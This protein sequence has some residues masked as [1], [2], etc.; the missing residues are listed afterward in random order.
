M[1]V[2]RQA[3][4]SG[5]AEVPHPAAHRQ[6]DGGSGML[7]KVLAWLL[8]VVAVVV[9]GW[10]L[11]KGF[12]TVTASSSVKGKQYQALFLT[13]GQVYFGK[14]SQLNGQ[15][16][17]LTNIYYLQVQQTVQPKDQTSSGNNQQVS[18]AKLGGELHGPEDV[19]YVNRDQVLFWENLKDNGKVVTA[20]KNYQSGGG[21]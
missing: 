14:L 20:I 1:D 21:K 11:A 7:S 10:F 13:N 4:D 5:M 18:L 3:N 16:V 19:M 12:S 9:L 2:R 8:I 6:A 15:Y 17:K